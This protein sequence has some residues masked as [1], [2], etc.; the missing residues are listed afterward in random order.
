MILLPLTNQPNQSFQVTIPLDDSNVVLDF[1]LY[2]NSIANYWQMTIKDA[3]TNLELLNGLPLL[4]GQDPLQNVLKQ[5]EY[6]KIGA[7]Y[8]IPLA[9]DAPDSPGISDWG[10][11]YVMVWGP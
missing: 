2:W 4:Y 1:V 11:N 9:K 6:L 7:A 8:L 5:W 3:L 10:V